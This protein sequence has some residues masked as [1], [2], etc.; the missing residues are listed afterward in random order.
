MQLAFGSLLVFVVA[1]AV[2]GAYAQKAYGD[3]LANVDWLHGTAESL[4]TF[5]NLF[6]VLALRRA[7]RRAK[8]LD[9]G[10]S[11]E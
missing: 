8:G 4:L 1:T 2:A 5:T 11:S 10:S 6:L 7:Y 9:Q 3:K